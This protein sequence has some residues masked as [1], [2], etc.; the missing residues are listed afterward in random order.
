MHI[1]SGQIILH[2][3]AK[4]LVCIT[5]MWFFFTGIS[6]VTKFVYFLLWLSLNEQEIAFLQ[7]HFFKFPVC[8]ALASKHS[9][10]HTH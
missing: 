9:H 2:Q 8:L 10:T 6:P 5:C 1:E 7:F 3:V 4:L